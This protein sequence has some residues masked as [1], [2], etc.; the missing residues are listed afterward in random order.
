ML[1]STLCWCW[2]QRCQRKTTLAVLDK[3]LGK[4]T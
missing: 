2:R 4:D 3:L 1:V